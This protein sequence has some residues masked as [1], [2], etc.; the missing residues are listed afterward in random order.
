[1]QSAPSC[2][3][4][5]VNSLV[6]QLVSY[7]DQILCRLSNFPCLQWTQARHDLPWMSNSLEVVKDLQRC[8]Q[9]F[10]YV[11]APLSRPSHQAAT[12]RQG[13]C[14][15]MKQKT[16]VALYA[17]VWLLWPLSAP[18]SPQT[19]LNPFTALRALC[20]LSSRDVL[21]CLHAVIG[22]CSNLHIIYRHWHSCSHLWLTYIPAHGI[23][24]RAFPA[25]L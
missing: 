16:S 21:A 25:Y 23:T 10:C 15:W 3:K 14:W 11:A 4:Y 7:Y 1:M 22:K 20:V 19:S 24:G 12:H 18:R 2:W 8:A 9:A 5:S 13:E 17:G 6:L